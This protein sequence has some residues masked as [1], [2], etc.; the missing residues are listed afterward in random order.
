MPGLA[1]APRASHTAAVAAEPAATATGAGNI[2][3]PTVRKIEGPAA[4]PIELSDV[5]GSAILKRLL[6][7]LGGLVVLLLVIR[8]LRR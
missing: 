7:A 4:E 8:R 1:P 6:P 5:A 3:A 2:P